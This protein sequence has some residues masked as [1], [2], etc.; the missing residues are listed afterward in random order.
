MKNHAATTWPMDDF[1][2]T[3][4]RKRTSALPHSRI[5]ID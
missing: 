1:I 3:I 4:D 5:E 2:N